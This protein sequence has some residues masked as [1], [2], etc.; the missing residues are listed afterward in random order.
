MHAWYS[1]VFDLFFTDFVIFNGSYDYVQ[2]HLFGNYD[3]VFLLKT[4]SV[5]GL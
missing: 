1:D 2:M 4:F 3:E 5:K